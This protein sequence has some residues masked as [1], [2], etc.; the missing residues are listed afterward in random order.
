VRRSVS[1]SAVLTAV[2]ILVCG[3]LST[4]GECPIGGIFA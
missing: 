3:F 4:L 1:Y 2:W